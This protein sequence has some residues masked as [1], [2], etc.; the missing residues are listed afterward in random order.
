MFVFL[1]FE[2]RRIAAT[3]SEIPSGELS[4]VSNAGESWDLVFSPNHTTK[5]SNDDLVGGDKPNTAGPRIVPSPRRDV[6]ASD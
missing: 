2:N 1:L 6:S 3:M 5:S 4:V